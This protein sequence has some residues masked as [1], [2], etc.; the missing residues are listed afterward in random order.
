MNKLNPVAY[1]RV[2]LYQFKE[3]KLIEGVRFGNNLFLKSIFS[4]LVVKKAQGW[5]YITFNCQKE[6]NHPRSHF[7]SKLHHSEATL[8]K[9]GQIP[10]TG[11]DYFPN[12]KKLGLLIIVAQGKMSSWHWHPYFPSEKWWLLRAKPNPTLLRISFLAVVV[13]SRSDKELQKAE[14]TETGRKL[15]FVF[16]PQKQ[17]WQWKWGGGRR[18]TS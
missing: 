9:T 18:K 6:K 16:I 14:S 8:C 15:S 7:T 1:F 11:W 5:K 2:T 3:N 13:W 4:C 10:L 17:V 12:W